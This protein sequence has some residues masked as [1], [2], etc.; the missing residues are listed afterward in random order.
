MLP[1]RGKMMYW[2]APMRLQVRETKVSVGRLLVEAR[3]VGM[4]DSGSS[5]LGLPEK[6]LA[7]VLEGLTD[8]KGGASVLA[9]TK[10][11]QLVSKC[12]A[13]LNDLV[14]IFYGED[15]QPFEVTLT[16]ED[17]LRPAAPDPLSILYG[18]LLGLDIIQWCQLKI[19]QTPETLNALIA[20]DPLFRKLSVVFDIEGHRVFMA[21][22]EPAPAAPVASLEA[23]P[24]IW[25]M[26]AAFAAV[27]AGIGTAVG[28]TRT[29]RQ[30]TDDGMY[31]AI[32]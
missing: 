11:G 16:K 6:L 8:G 19:L 4:L 25:P 7:V 23:L 10:S 28:A 29:P 27:C 18:H 26:W 1:V 14:F 5:F 22:V 15:D 21:P 17:L 2:A 30:Q 32:E 20:G 31:L 24:K 12:D 9:Q 3:G 13:D